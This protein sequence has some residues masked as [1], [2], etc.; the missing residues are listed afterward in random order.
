MESDHETNR[1][2]HLS[3]DFPLVEGW[4]VGMPR[5]ARIVIA[6]QPHDVVQRGSN[7][8]DVFFVDD[9]RR[10]AVEKLRRSAAAV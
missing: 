2:S 7:R 5:M 1:D 8:Q 3:I 10:E 6:G 4:V 9:D